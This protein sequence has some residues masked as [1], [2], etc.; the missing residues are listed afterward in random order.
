MTVCLQQLLKHIDKSPFGWSN[1]LKDGK[2]LVHKNTT[3]EDILSWLKKL[4]QLSKY[5]KE[6]ELKVLDITGRTRT[7]IRRM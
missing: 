4:D 5:V 3:Q 1:E 7:S 6:Q 2:I